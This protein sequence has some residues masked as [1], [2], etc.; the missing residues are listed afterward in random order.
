MLTLRAV[1]RAT[2]GDQNAAN[3]CA[4]AAT[5]LASPLVHAMLHLEKAGFAGGIDVVGDGGSAETD[6]V[7]KDLAQREAEPF[8]FGTAE[9]AG[10]AAGTDAGV[11]EALIGIN[12]ANPGE[13]RLVE[14]TRLDGESAAPE[15]GGEGLCADGKRF[16]AGGEEGGSVAEVLVGEAAEASGVDEAQFAAAGEGEARVGV[17]GDGSGRICDEQA[18]GHAEVNNPLGFGELGIRCFG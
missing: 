18:A 4:A 17:G 12:V 2:A 7:P 6:G 9:A 1:M 8:E 11:E 13:E 10:H 3:G 15:E 5:G 14:E 16:Q